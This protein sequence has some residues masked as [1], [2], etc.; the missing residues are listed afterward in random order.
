[1]KRIRAVIELDFH[2][3][4][5]DIGEEEILLALEEYDKE[6]TRLISFEIKELKIADLEKEI[7]KKLDEDLVPEARDEIFNM[8][9]NLKRCKE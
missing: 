9:E 8:I 1:M 5:N 4:V 7:F 2:K 3:D 6:F